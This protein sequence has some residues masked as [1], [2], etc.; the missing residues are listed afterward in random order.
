[1]STQQKTAEG[2]RAE[3]DWLKT[4]ALKIVKIIDATNYYE[5]IRVYTGL[6][7]MAEKKWRCRSCGEIAHLS[8]DIKH[9]E[10]VCLVYLANKIREKY[11]EQIE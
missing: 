4:H 7:G 10:G 1:M 8:I 11:D 6:F 9:D 5:Y 2:V 3:L